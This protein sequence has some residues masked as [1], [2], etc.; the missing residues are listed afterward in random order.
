[1]KLESVKDQWGGRDQHDSSL[2]VM[3]LMVIFE[4]LKSYKS[5]ED[6]RF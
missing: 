1:M 4:N 3:T 2:S 5:L 6:K